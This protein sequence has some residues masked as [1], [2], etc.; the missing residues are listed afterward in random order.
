[1]IVYFDTCSSSMHFFVEAG[2]IKSV[3]L[4]PG[5]GEGGCSC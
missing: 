4:A 3:D 5:Q 1:M 2:K